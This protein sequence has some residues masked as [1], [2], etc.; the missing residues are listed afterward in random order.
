MNNP[1][2]HKSKKIAIC[3]KGLPSCDNICPAGEDIQGWISLAKEKKFRQAWELIIQSNPFPA[4]HGRVCYHY[5]ETRCN[6]IQY[7]TT[8][9]IHCIERFL[10]DMALENGWTA[11]ASGAKTG[12]KI[13]VVGGGPAGLS[14]SYYLRL[15][16]HDVTIYEA[17]SKL[18]G[19]MLVGIPAYR[20]PRRV[21][22]GEIDRILKIG[23]K[24]EYNH[25]VEDVI[26][27]KQY[28]GFD[29]VFLAIG[30]HLGKN[31]ALSLENP[32]KVMDA[33]DYL[34]EVSFGVD[35]KLGSRMVIYGGGNTGIDVARSAKRLG[36]SDIT[37][38]YHRTREKMSAFP[39]EI[40][41]ALAEGIK[42]TFL[43]SI[44]GLNQNTLTL[45]VNEMD[46]KGRSK[47]TGKVETVQTDTLIFA[48]SQ[49]PDSEFLHKIPE[50]EV[51]PNGVVTVDNFFM[52]GYRGIFAGGDAIPYDRSVTVAVGQGRQAAY[53]INAYL[54]DT[55]FSKAPNLE[56]IHFDRLHID[57]EKSK[58]TEQ[59]TLDA[60]IRIKSFDEAV[61]GSTQ[62]EI[63]Y[64]ANRCF[65]CGNCFGCGKCY[66]ICP[67]KVITHSESDG[68]VTSIDT[69]KCIGCG[70]C[71]KICPCGAMTMVDRC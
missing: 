24:V 34:R 29:A 15:M 57:S 71:F 62:D 8:V 12:K 68:R 48:L 20:L 35:H 61:H 33:I 50:V 19:T 2:G 52:T 23:V 17:L 27:E 28:G 1:S 22:S 30:A 37:I 31:T 42:F 32:C 16:G 43:R 47:N 21:L 45:S 53:H 46:E 64:E 13:L 56:L 4:I 69:D 63:L 36:V 58:K 40:D 44:T 55:V 11:P 70:K 60:D 54:N 65:S 66:A 25:R 38:I 26:K 6:R 3:T 67:V 41:D 9:S 14:A 18:G 51:Q 59:K 5:C 39:Q 10:G 49:T 7:D